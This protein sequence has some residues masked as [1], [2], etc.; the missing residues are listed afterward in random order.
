MRYGSTVFLASQRD[1][2]GNTLLFTRAGNAGNLTAITD[3]AS[4]RQLLLT[5]DGLNRIT[6]IVDPLGRTV[7]YG[8]EGNNLATVTDPAGGVTRYTYDS[9]GRMLT[10]TDARSITFLTNEYDAQGRVSRQTQADTGVW[11]FAYTTAGSTIVQTAVTDPRGHT[12]I[13][14]FNG[15]GYPISLTDALGQTT[16]FTRDPSS[17]LLLATTDP[18]GRTTRY[19]YDETGNLRT[20]TDPLQQ[21]RT[22]TYH[23][24]WNLVTSITDPLENV[25]TFEYDN[26][27]NLLAI[28]D[29]E[30]HL[31]PE[32]ERL[33]TRFTYN[34]Y[35]QPVTATDPLNHTT[36][37]EYGGVGNVTAIIDPLG[38]ATVRTYDAVSRLL[39]QTDPLGKTTRFSYDALN[40]VVG[41]SDA[42]Q[43]HTGF[44]YDPNG[45]LRTVTDAQGH[46]TTH[47]Y[48]PMD[49]LERRID[50][51]GKAETFAHD[52]NGNL[53]RT[54]DRKN[55]TTA[56]TYDPLNR[57]TRAEYADGS[58]ASFTYDAGGRLLQADDT[59]DPHRPITLTYDPLDRLLT[60]T[61]ALGTV[62]Y[63]YDAL[64]RRTRMTVSGQPPVAYAYDH[65]SRLRAITQAPLSPA[66]LDY[67][68]A[69]RRTL[70]TLPNGVSTEYV[71]DLGSRLTALIYRNALGLLG[72]LVYGYDDA[73]NRTSVSGAFARTLLPDPVPTSTYDAGNRQLAFGPSGMAFDDNGNLVTQTDAAGTTTYAWDARNR[74]AGLSG[75]AVTASFA[76]DAL[77]RRAQKSVNGLLTSFHYD[78]LDAIREVGGGGEAHYLRTL[79]I[80]EVLAR[81]DAGDTLHYVADALGSSVALV[82]ES[83]TAHTTYTYEPFGHTAVD[84]PAANPVQYTGRENDGTALYYY[85][86]R[87]HDPRRGRFINEDP[88]GLASQSTN[89]YAYVASNPTNVV[90]PSGLLDTRAPGRGRPD[91]RPFPR[92]TRSV[93]RSVQEPPPRIGGVP[94]SPEQGGAHIPGTPGTPH[95]EAAPSTSKSTRAA[96]SLLRSLQPL[97]RVGA[98]IGQLLGRLLPGL[99]PLAMPEEIL[100]C[101]TSPSPEACV[102]TS[103]TLVQASID[104]SGDGLDALMEVL[105]DGILPVDVSPRK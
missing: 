92:Q 9:Q 69:G 2:Y 44:E 98:A 76:Y 23:P 68:A 103:S 75:P 84:G 21:T 59:A 22:F 45:N 104:G 41:I 77:G 40:R 62:G 13:H 10:L 60:E 25:T 54:T 27:G 72:D 14:R 20:V 46:T 91:T 56:F 47:E 7:S 53:S 82:T 38:H 29:P 86:A 30:Q 1:R 18:L 85:R 78:G 39:S 58:A 17:N 43:G 42:L 26:V 90:D 71:Y 5:Y 51:L 16:T 101:A 6:S 70:L 3:P 33:K 94:P 15:H 61:T 35:G 99:Y 87:Y 19:T 11:A 79:A 49:R 80:D 73:G 8:Y 100:R 34:E 88:I 81:T 65:N 64:G 67:D 83:G 31:R 48:D 12:T 50:P 32:A 105:M 93:P 96:A 97:M 36:T 95:P 55:Q 52:G 37:F 28:T 57:R 4:G 89:L 66:A 74:L 24:T 102:R 63:Q